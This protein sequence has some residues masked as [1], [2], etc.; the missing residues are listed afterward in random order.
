MKKNVSLMLPCIAVVIFAAIAGK[1]AF[2]PNSNEVS[3][4]LAQNVE[5]LSNSDEGGYDSSE[6]NNGVDQW[7]SV[8]VATGKAQTR[9][10]YSDGANG[11]YGMDEIFDIEYKRCAAYG[12]GSKKGANF[13]WPTGKGPS[14]YE[15]CK[16][17]NGHYG[18]T[19]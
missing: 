11:N 17:A 16:G 7:A 3:D 4:L 2:L 6:C 10:H 1:K 5:A 18:P 14:T 19:F 13:S 8:E 12:R 15:E 9:V